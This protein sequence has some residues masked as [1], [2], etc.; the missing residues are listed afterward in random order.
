MTPTSMMAARFH[1]V[2][3]PLQMEEVPV[4]EIREDEVLVQV[5]AVGLCGSDVH[6]VFEGVTPTP[7]KPIILGHEPCGVV[8]ATGA[9]VEGWE[10]GDRVSVTPLL[11]C[12]SCRNCITG[13]TNVCL[14]RKIMGIQANGALAEYLAVPAK[15]LVR[16]PEE[17]PFTVGAIITDAVATPF[18][19]MAERAALRAG[20]TVAV[21]GAGGLGLHAVQICRLLGAQKI[22]VVDPREGQ[23]ERAREMGAD[24][25]IDPEE[26]PPVEAILETTGGLGVDV[27][28]EFVG[29]QGTIA[30]CVE[31]VARGGRVVVAGLGADPISIVPPTVFVRDGI[32]LL[33]SYGFTKRNIEQLVELAA[34]GR[35]N[36]EESITHT[37]PLDEVNTALKYLHEKIENPIRVA[38]TL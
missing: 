9:R 23:L 25:T 35:L 14:T 5:K 4:P 8:A 31:S 12:S 18:Q 7:F 28:A 15:N 21:F 27:A 38:V 19:A 10:E 29:L 24:L 34:A 6:I 2:N 22:I 20:E 37:F 3:E 1:E 33:G 16:L 17:V 30:Q 32:S 11:F 36:L 26:T 13:H